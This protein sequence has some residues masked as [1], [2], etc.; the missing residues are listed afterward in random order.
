[1]LQTKDIAKRINENPEVFNEVINEYKVKLMRYILSLTD[2]SYIDAESLLQD[3]FIK[4]YTYI[5]SYNGKDSFSGWIFRI[6]R[7]MTIDNY[8]KNRTVQEDISLQDDEFK[9]VMDL[10]S[11]WSSPHKEL[12]ESDIRSCVQKAISMLKKEYKEAIIL[13]CIEWYNY[14]EISDILKVPVW[15]ASTLVNRARKELKVN[16]VNLKCNS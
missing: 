1:M 13:K 8:R 6:A 11:D 14:D 3:I 5:N 15:T 9:N 4:V 16:L 2:I 7:N 12:L 10:L